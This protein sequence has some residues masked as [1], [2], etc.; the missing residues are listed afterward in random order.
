MT[1]MPSIARCRGWSMPCR[2]ARSAIRRC[3]SSWRAACPEVMLHLRRLGLLDLER[4]TVTGEP[5]GKVLDWWENSERRAR[6][7]ANL[8]PARRR[9]S[10]HVIMSPEQAQARGLTSTVTFPRGNLAPEGS[11]IKSTAI[12]PSVVD[13]DG[14][15]RKLGP[16][17]VFTTERAAIAAIKTRPDPARRRPRAD[18]PGTD[19]IGHGGDLPDHLGAEAPE[20]R[21]AR[22]RADR[23]PLLRRVHRCV[24][25]PRRP[26]GAGRRTDRQGARR[27]SAFRSSSIATV[28][29]AASIWWAKEKRSSAPRREPAFWPGVPR[30]RTSPPTRSCPRTHAC[31]PPCSM[32]AAA[33]GAAACTTSMQSSTR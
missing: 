14:V 3:A 18:L 15:Y 33:P 24:H 25:R 1:G 31:G 23:R 10:G 9:R 28:W 17:R 11:V 2:T 13:A 12:D 16:A 27:R 22:G 5:L 19:G 20:L 30:A 29:K 26:R 4:L 32:S 21:Q 7:R 6:L 8:A